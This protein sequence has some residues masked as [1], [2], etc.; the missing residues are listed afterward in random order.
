MQRKQCWWL[1]LSK[2]PFFGHERHLLGP[3][4]LLLHP[5]NGYV[6]RGMLCARRPWRGP[7]PRG[8]RTVPRATSSRPIFEV[9]DGVNKCFRLFGLCSRNTGFA[10]RAASDLGR[11]RDITRA[12]GRVAIRPSCFSA[13]RASFRPRLPPEGKEIFATAPHLSGQAAASTSAGLC[14]DAFSARSSSAV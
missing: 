8:E 9:F 14:R 5:C 10:P 4:S 3:V 12:D 7:A 2:V 1:L 13:R 11:V 6:A